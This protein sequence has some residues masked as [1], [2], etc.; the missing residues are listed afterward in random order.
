M[1]FNYLL[2]KVRKI[3]SSNILAS[4]FFNVYKLKRWD[5]RPF[6]Y[7]RLFTLNDQSKFN[8]NAKK[9]PA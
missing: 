5:H 9:N 7:V 3:G 6:R 4:R 8:L 2:G 1:L